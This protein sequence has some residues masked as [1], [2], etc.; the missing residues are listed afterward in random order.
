MAASPGARVS[1]R[2][3][4]LRR[5]VSQFS[6]PAARDPP[7]SSAVDPFVG[8]IPAAGSTVGVPKGGTEWA[9]NVG[10]KTDHEFPIELK[11]T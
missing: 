4:R 10:A 9:L 3:A 5:C 11:K 1:L 6:H 7:K 2:V 8:N